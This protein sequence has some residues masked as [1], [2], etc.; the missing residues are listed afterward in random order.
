MA[1]IIAIYA[2]LNTPVPVYVSGALFIV[3]GL[4]VLLV[5]YESQGRASL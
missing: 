1:P 3:A 2:N 5:P 4:L